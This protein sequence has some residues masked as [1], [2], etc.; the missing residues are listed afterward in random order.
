MSM[1]STVGHAVVASSSSSSSYSSSSSPLPR[2]LP[3]RRRRPPRASPSRSGAA[4]GVCSSVTAS[5]PRPRAAKQL[6]IVHFES[7]EPMR[8]DRRR[9]TPGK[10][11]HPSLLARA[12]D[13]D[14]RSP[15]ARKGNVRRAFERPLAATVRPAA[16]AAK[17]TDG[18]WLPGM[19]G[20]AIATRGVVPRGLGL[21]LARFFAFFASFF[22]RFA[23]FRSLRAVARRRARRRRPARRPPRPRRP[24]APVRAARRGRARS[25]CARARAPRSCRASSRSTASPLDV[26][27]PPRRRGAEALDALDVEPVAL[28]GAA[29][30]EL[31]DLVRLELHVDRAPLLHRQAEL[32]GDEVVLLRAQARA[33]GRG[34]GPPRRA[35]LLGAQGLG[36]RAARVPKQV[37]AL[38]PAADGRELRVT[39]VVLAVLVRLDVG[40]VELILAAAAPPSRK[41][42]LGLRVVILRHKRRRAGLVPSS[43]PRLGGVFEL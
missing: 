9:S 30:E 21:L 1:R 37:F 20:H 27:V 17:S 41:P 13:H 11:R 43:Y 39:Q 25:G 24:R 34:L 3:W 38:L 28:D 36:P 29:L 2:P 40:P 4:R 5:E 32:L 31:R 10:R 12:V 42:V 33:L 8:L 14:G 7:R 15:G 23:S 18:T 16:D 6:D 22:A 19:P 26:L 35:R